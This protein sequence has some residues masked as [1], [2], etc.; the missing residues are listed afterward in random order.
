MVAGGGGRA[1]KVR[2]LGDASDAIRAA[3]ATSLAFKGLDNDVSKSSKGFD[4]FS[5]SAATAGKT[6]SVTLKATSV[7]MAALGAASITHVAGAT[8][9]LGGLSAAAIGAVGA[10]G[11]LGIVFASQNL[12]V[13][14]SFGKLLQDMK[15]EM[16]EV[17]AA[18]VPAM[19][20]ISE[21]LRAVFDNLAP[22]LKPLFD[23]IAPL[24]T[25]FSGTLLDGVVLLFPVFKEFVQAGIPMVKWINDHLLPIFK[26]LS[27]FS[28]LS[29]IQKLTDNVGPLLDTLRPVADAFAQLAVT[30][31]G[32]LGAAITAVLPSLASFL[33]TLGTSIAPVLASIATQLAPVMT[34]V[35]TALEPI[36]PV[37]GEM[38]VKVVNEM[39]PPLV[40]LFTKLGPPVT[41]LLEAITPILPQ[42][43]EL[44][45]TILT[46]LATSLGP[47]LE[48]LTPLITEL[49]DRL[50]PIIDQLNPIIKDFGEKWGDEIA[51]NI[52][53][54]TP[55]IIALVDAL[56]P[57][58]PPMVDLLTQIL[59]FEAQS[60]GALINFFKDVAYWV[61]EV[62]NKLTEL[63]NNDAWRFV[64]ET[65]GGVAGAAGVAN[66][67]NFGSMF[68]GVFGALG[69]YDTGGIVPGPKGKP[70]LAVVHS[71]ETILPT[72][73]MGLQA[74]LGQVIHEDDPRWDWRTMGNRTN[75]LGED[76]AA[77]FA[78]DEAAGA[79]FA[80]LGW[81]EEDVRAIA[82]LIARG[83][84]PAA[85]G[86][87]VVNVYAQGSVTTER[88][89]VQ[90]IRSGLLQADRYGR[91]GTP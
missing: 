19:L 15:A 16:Q 83:G 56:L 37:L 51:T 47:V 4:L 44:A 34:S 28:P 42:L 63:Q 81:P 41:G 1:L 79:S 76:G 45:G 74:A 12:A 50:K 3:K 88:D 46:A 52:K 65:F 75:G 59:L 66:P 21:R 9:L 33:T 90:T 36:L 48:A 35:L 58:V 22:Q 25:E 2:I 57:L 77:R 8:A 55:D 78:A 24:V 85:A 72:H 5:S 49:V 69:M 61:G 68:G 7:G 17:S 54:L 43:T 23:E 89:L 80:A 26:G 86:A 62:A 29:F 84:A 32:P 30:V 39:G 82:D 64:T 73:E 18:F 87:P 67:E 91:G 60:T 71:G 70:V 6:L 10:I 38:L 53:D 27:A 31:A 14:G 40:D 20:L 11:G 13:A